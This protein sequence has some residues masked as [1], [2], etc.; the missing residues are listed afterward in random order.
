MHATRRMCKNFSPPQV[1][2]SS[3]PANGVPRIGCRALHLACQPDIAFSRPAISSQPARENPDESN[4]SPPSRTHPARL[5]GSV[6]GPGSGWARVVTD[7]L[8]GRETA[9]RHT[10]CM[11]HGLVESYHHDVYVHCTYCR[12]CVHVCIEREGGWLQQSAM[13]LRG[14]ANHHQ[15][16]LPQLLHSMRQE[17]SDDMGGRRSCCQHSAALAMLFQPTPEPGHRWPHLH[18]SSARFRDASPQTPRLVLGHGAL[19]RKPRRPLA[20]KI[21]NLIRTSPSALPNSSFPGPTGRGT[22]PDQGYFTAALPC[23]PSSSPAALRCCSLEARGQSMQDLAPTAPPTSVGKGIW[24]QGLATRTRELKLSQ[25]TL[26]TGSW[27]PAHQAH[28]QPT[29]AAPWRPDWS[30][31]PPSVVAGATPVL[32]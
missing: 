26:W 17:I 15:P 13:V 25:T 23:Q 28:Q 2:F 27:R 31:A 14:A 32:R 24:A 30:M 1:E 7:W 12:V 4:D 8:T 9:Y 20:T 22:S 10:Q 3:T 5:I 6:H 16:V 19:C 21:T 18:L 29:A 11:N